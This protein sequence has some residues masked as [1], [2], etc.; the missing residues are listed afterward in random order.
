M[1]RMC[2]LVDGVSYVCVGWW[3]GWGTYVWV[4]WVGCDTYVW[5]GGWDVI[6]TCG[7]GGW[8]VI[9]MCGWGV[10]RMTA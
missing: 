10:I 4:G 3:V 9:R 7:W 5:V 2:G 1:I 6:R 8:G